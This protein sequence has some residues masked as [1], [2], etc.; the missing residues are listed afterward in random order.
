M[1]V[2][3]TR[4]IRAR[5][6]ARDKVDESFL[7]DYTKLYDYCHELLRSNPGSTDKMNVELV[8]KGV[9]DQKPYFKSLCIR[10]AAYKESF[11]LS[12]HVIGLNGCFLNGLWVGGRILA[13]I[14]RDPNN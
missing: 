7:G 2:N 4:A 8:L 1:G 6:A 11:K 14:G 12:R 13:V 10:Y 9:G 5:V 3:K